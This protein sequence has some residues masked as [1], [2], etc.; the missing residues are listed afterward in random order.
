MWIDLYVA[1]A[2]VVAGAAW[3]VS[4]QYLSYDPPSDVVRAFAA[5]LAGALWPLVIVGLGQVLAV[6]YIARRLRGAA[7][8]PGVDLDTLVAAPTAGL[9]CS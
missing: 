5:V 2:I 8:T 7:P 3:L 9:H 4:R 6:R 1:A